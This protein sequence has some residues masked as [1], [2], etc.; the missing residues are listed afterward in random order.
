VI[1]SA[2]PF[3]AL[4]PLTAYGLWKLRQDVFVV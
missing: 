2:Q 1:I 4:D 3:A